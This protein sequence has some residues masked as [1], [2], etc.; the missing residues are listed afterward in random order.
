M[1][2]NYRIGDLIEVPPVQTVV[3]L[4]NSSEAA[5]NAAGTFVFTSDVDVHIRILAEALD[6]SSGQGYFL[7]GDFGSGKSHFLAALN[8]WLGRNDVSGAFRAQHEG[9]K[10][11]HQS[12]KCFLPV[13]ISLVNFR[14]NTPLE[15]IIT[16]SIEECLRLRNISAVISERSFFLQFLKGILNVPGICSEFSSLTGAPSDRIAEWID[17]HRQEA[18]SAGWLLIKNKGLGLPEFPIRERRETFESALQ[19]VASEGFAGIV[20]LIDELSEFFRSKPDGSSLNE[21]A[22]TLQLLGEMSKSNPLWI[23]AAVQES[24]ERTGDIAQA[25]FRKIKDRFGI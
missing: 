14:G 4:E 5:Q 1:L 16:E 19:V 13:P 21:D 25:T 8:A 15:R 3:R 12:G 9:L 10:K 24:I 2:P 23:V 6:R 22:R 20:L 11:L 18:F 17:E 7:Q